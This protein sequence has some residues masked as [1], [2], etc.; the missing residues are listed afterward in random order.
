[1][2]N[3]I[4]KSGSFIFNN[5]EINKYI[6]K[7]NIDCQYYLDKQSFIK[8]RKKLGMTQKNFS[9]FLG[10]SERMVQRIEAKK[11]IGLNILNRLEKVLGQ[12]KIN[13]N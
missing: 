2:N 7:N 8:L 3:N 11:Y 13:W 9:N 1:M 4:Q 6:N 12:W 5:I 10:I